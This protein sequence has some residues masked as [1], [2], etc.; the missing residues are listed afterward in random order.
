MYVFA[1]FGFNEDGFIISEIQE[2]VYVTL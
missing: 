1:T 2:I